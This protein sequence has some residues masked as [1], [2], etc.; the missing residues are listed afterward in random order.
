MEPRLA[1][2][3]FKI[4]DTHNFRLRL[5]SA[6]V[7][8]PPTLAAVIIGGW[9]YVAVVVLYSVM[10][11]RE[12]LRMVDPTAHRL[13]VIIAYIFLLLMIGIGALVL[14]V[15]GALVGTVFVLVLFLF[16]A[17]DHEDRAGWI[18]LGLPYMGGFG[19]AFLYLRSISG[20]GR[21]LVYYLLAVVWAT[22]IGAYISGRLIG[23][24]KLA[25]AISPK[26]TWAGLVGYGFG[27]AFWLCCGSFIQD[28]ATTCGERFCDCDRGHFAAGR[29]V[30]VLYQKARGREGKWRPHTWPW[31]RSRPHRRVDFRS[32]I[33]CSISGRCTSALAVVVIERQV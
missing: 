29:F 25:P 12:W 15:L 26:K 5:L 30:R 33:F 13:V 11:L 17:R 32:H 28:A 3:N 31:R 9:F 23:G 21:E 1:G 10:G 7:L 4:F 16:A 14:P 24:P 18:A 6:L 8:I 22:D 19:L 2:L 27:G 20:I